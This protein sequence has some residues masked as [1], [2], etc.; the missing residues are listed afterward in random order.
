MAYKPSS[1]SQLYIL[2]SQRSM[3]RGEISLCDDDNLEVFTPYIVLPGSYCGEFNSATAVGG[4]HLFIYS[5]LYSAIPDI[6]LLQE[7]SFS[8]IYCLHFLL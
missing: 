7:R 4:P 6:S 2:D 5:V 8:S 3:R 1:K